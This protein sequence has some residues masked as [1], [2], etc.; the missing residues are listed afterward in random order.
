LFLFSA[1]GGLH[2]STIDAVWVPVADAI[3]ALLSM[4]LCGNRGKV[5]SFRARQ[6]RE[7]V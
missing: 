1:P 3:A 6:T 4:A 5:A 7:F 2:V